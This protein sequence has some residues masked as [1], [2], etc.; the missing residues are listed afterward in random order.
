MPSPQSLVLRFVLAAG[1]GVVADPG[2][3]LR[4]LRVVPSGDASPTTAVTVTFDRPVAGSLDRTVDPGAVFAIAPAVAGA[5]DWRDPVTLRFRPAAPLTPNTSYTVTVANSFAAMDGSRLREPYAFTFRVRGPR[6]LAGSPIGPNGGTPYLA[7]DA[8]FDLVVD[9]PVDP[10][11][12]EAAVYLMFNRLCGRPGAVRLAVEGQRAI[13]ADD[14]WD[15]REAGGWDRDRSADPLR[16]V[17][18]LAPRTPLPHGCGGELVVPTAF[19]QRSWAQPLRWGLA[20]YGD[21]RL[22]RAGCGW[23]GIAFCP[24]GPL[25]LRFSTPVRGADVQR[26]IA[27]RPAVPFELG[28]TS[29][30]RADWV[31]DATLRPHTA[32]A[33]VA[34]AALRDG[35]GQALTGNPVATITTTG[36]A[37]AIN[38][39]PGR[40]VVERK[41]AGTFALTF[42][43]V[44]TL[45]VVTAP[46]P[47]S[48]EAA[49]LARSEWRW[50]E[51]WPALLPTARRDRIPVTSPR[52]RVRVYGVKLAAP[53]YRRP[54]TPTL[55]A[56]QVT[57]R[58]LDS[59]SRRQRPI[60]LLQVTDLGVH[61]RVGSE[62]GVVWV[63]GRERRAAPGGRRGRAARR[64]GPDHRPVGDGHE[65]HRPAHRLRLGL[66]GRRGRGGRGGRGLQLSGLRRASSS[67]PTGRSSASTTTTPT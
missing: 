28:D 47:D 2:A 15:F 25:V 54:G 50:N 46:V 27:L 63:T 40:A 65:R 11:A 33:V 42:V 8:R 49:F 39:A 4:V 22:A 60:A 64:E 44:D 55:L 36:Y 24:T 21:F 62:D 31:L 14:R 5:V 43:N 57:S 67:A 34:D 9:A 37:P 13:T 66:G 56:V 7:P 61:A 20:T 41:G 26:H 16:R 53:E 45:E 3:D 17:V 32:Y 52:D 1:L 18:R 30:V 19:D 35:F 10:A 12:V 58:G 48:L 51:L 38:Y 29:D 59:L 23:E 6:V